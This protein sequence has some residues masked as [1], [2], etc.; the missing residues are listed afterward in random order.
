MSTSSRQG[1]EKEEITVSCGDLQS[2]I[3]SEECT[4]ITWEHG[5]EVVEPID[6]ERPHT[7]PVSYV[8]LSKHHFQFGVRFPLNPFFIEVLRYFGLTVFQI[9]PNGWAHMIG[10]FGLFTEQVMGPPTAEEFAW[11]YSVK[12]NKNDEGFYYFAKRPVKGL[13]AVVKIRDNLGI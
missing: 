1:D 13:Q 2:S 4:W 8:T 6:L 10:L 3:T 5:H 7:S 11:F 12:S 9:T